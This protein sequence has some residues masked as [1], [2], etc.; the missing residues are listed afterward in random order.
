[1]AGMYLVEEN[2]CEAGKWLKFFDT[3]SSK[4]ASPEN[5]KGFLLAVRD[6]CLAEDARDEVPNFVVGELTKMTRS[7]LINS[8]GPKS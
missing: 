8:A 6:C 4:A 1:L 5:T 2:K 7:G 3:V